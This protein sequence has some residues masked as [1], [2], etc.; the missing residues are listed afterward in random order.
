MA[1]QACTRSFIA[2]PILSNRNR[3]LVC[4]AKEEKKKKKNLSLPR[5]IA[6]AP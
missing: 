1:I 6:T 4:E 3:A 2:S 5:P